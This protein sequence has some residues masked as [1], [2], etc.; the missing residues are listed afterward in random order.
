MNLI[1]GLT[2]LQYS[3]QLTQPFFILY[4]Y[5]AIC[6]YH[7]KFPKL[8]QETLT[9]QQ[10]V[11]LR[12]HISNTNFFFTYIHTKKSKVLSSY[13]NLKLFIIYVREVS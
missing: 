8:V 1:L 7:I 6:F 4:Q 9:I 10:F 3:S 11:D 2:I 12:Y 13:G 5:F